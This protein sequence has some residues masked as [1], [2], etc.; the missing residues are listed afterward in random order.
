MCGVSNPLFTKDVSSTERKRL[1][2]WALVTLV[3]TTSET[4]IHDLVGGW[5]I[6][7]GNHGKFM[8]IRICDGDT[9]SY[10]WW[11]RFLFDFHPEK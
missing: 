2:C 3:G 10:R 7:V 6:V 5:W 4:D 11:F 1:G 8:K 9:C